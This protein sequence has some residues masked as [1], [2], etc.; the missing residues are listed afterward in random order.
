[1]SHIQGGVYESAVGIIGNSYTRHSA[2]TRAVPA[3]GGAHQYLKC[4]C[5][6]GRTPRPKVSA[7]VG[8]TRRDREGI[9]IFKAQNG[10]FNKLN[11]VLGYVTV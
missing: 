9:L 11:G 4:P 10:G 3:L 7:K 1:M 5:I 8:F 6:R 2:H